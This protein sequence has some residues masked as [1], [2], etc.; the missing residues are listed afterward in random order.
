MPGG[1]FPVGEDEFRPD[2]L[3]YQDTRKGY[4]YS[5]I[6]RNAEVMFKGKAGKTGRPLGSPLQN[7]M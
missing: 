5:G 2:I 7:H 3:T 6:T 1:V 4:P